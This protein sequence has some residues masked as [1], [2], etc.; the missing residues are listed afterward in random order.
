LAA[1]TAKFGYIPTIEQYLKAMEYIEP[2]HDKIYQYLNFD[3]LDEYQS[4]LKH[5]KLDTI[6]E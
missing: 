6:L 2:K 5:I 4:T 1:I 3:Q